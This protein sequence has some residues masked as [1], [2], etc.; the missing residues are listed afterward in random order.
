MTVHSIC[1]CMHVCGLCVCVC[2]W[3]GVCG[4]LW[5][6]EGIMFVC[7][8]ACMRVCLHA[9]ICVYLE[10]S[11][12]ALLFL[13]L[14]RLPGLPSYHIGDGYFSVG[15][16]SLKC[17]NINS[18]SHSLTEHLGHA[19]THTYS[20]CLNLI[21]VCV[22][23]CVCVRACVLMC[24]CVHVFTCVHAF[25]CIC[26]WV[27]VCMRERERESVC[28]CV[29]VCVLVSRTPE[30]TEWILYSLCK[31]GQ[32]REGCCRC[33]NNDLYQL[34]S[35]WCPVTCRCCL[36]TY[37]DTIIHHHRTARPATLPV[38]CRLVHTS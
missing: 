7:V 24:V 19:D 13:C 4:Y 35:S 28:V 38:L 25:T 33:G 31:H 10:A 3:V 34:P 32:I 36:L 20:V 18:V 5:K 16:P 23:V 29:C 26:L 17:C 15:F 12:L 2:V 8:H 30:L 37:T 6:G 27:C 21:S 22:C 11:S 9:C 14:P 1:M